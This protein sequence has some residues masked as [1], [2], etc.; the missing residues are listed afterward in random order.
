MLGMHEDVDFSNADAT[1]DHSEGGPFN[2]LNKRNKIN[3]VE[4]FAYQ[5]MR[6]SQDSAMAHDISECQLLHKGAS[7]E[8]RHNIF[9]MGTAQSKADTVGGGKMMESAFFGGN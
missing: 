9:K 7:E 3:Q 2:L 8:P 5:D 4:D 6:D 1:K